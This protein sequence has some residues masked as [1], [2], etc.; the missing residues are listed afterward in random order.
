MA[1]RLFRFGN[2]AIKWI[3]YFLFL[4]TVY[5][6]LTSANIIL[7]DNVVTGSGTTLYTAWFL[8]I[9][10]SLIVGIWA[11][12][13]WYHWFQWAFIEHQLVTAGLLLGLAVIWQ[14]IFVSC[15][16]PAIG[17]DTG[18]IHAALLDPTNANNRGY[19]SQNSNNLPI[20]LVQHWLSQLFHQTSWLFFDIVTTILV[21]LSAILN[22]GSVRL[23]DRTKVGTAM[24]IHAIWLFLFPMII[25]PYTDAWVL[26]LVSL[27]L[28]SYSALVSRQRPAW[29]QVVWTFI[30]GLATMAAYFMK[31]SAIVP[32][33]A[34]GLV[35]FIFLFKRRPQWLRVIGLSLIMAVTLGGG[36][37]VGNQQLDN[38]TFIRL[39]AGRSIPAVHFM[40]MG[41]SGDGGYNADDALKMIELPTYQERAA[42]SKKKL[43][44][45]LKKR[46]FW[47]YLTFLFQ[48]Q[49]N[50]TADGSF[51]WIKEG[52]F[53]RGD[54]SPSNKGFAGKVR[55]F[56]YLYGTNLGDFRY[57]A[58]VWW[59]V[60]L[61]I[62]F[63]GGRSRDRYTQMLRLTI[64]GGGIFLLL[65]EGGR[66]RYLIQFLPAYLL[67]AS[68][69]FRDAL[70]V[71][72]RLFGWVNQP[73]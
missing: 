6:A 41:V 19:I 60:W 10:I 54:S 7:G 5:F 38:Q 61:L 40:S 26:P 39:T 20:L 9:T 17:W 53:I 12:R 8:I 48:K 27:V 36:Y 25:V 55:N 51:A 43:V 28:L 29:V 73:V 57:I 52:H 42:Y 13:R 44:Q 66:S 30:L 68:L 16:H 14:V 23:L 21:D 69:V 58:Q 62:I 33:I 37:V 18:T 71:F 46:G 64:V 3:F 11:Y 72:K 4:L 31:P 47:G 65:F 70:A 56:F 15:M 50:N 22:I 1:Q 45:R 2:R 24:Y 32:I 59:I 63:L 35:E 34:I 67:L 49:A